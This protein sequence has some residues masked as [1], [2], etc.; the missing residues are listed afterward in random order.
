MKT[1]IGY[2]YLLDDLPS[3]YSGY[4]I[5]TNFTVG[6]KISN[7]FEDDNLDEYTQFELAIRLLFEEIPDDIKLAIDGVF[8]FMNGGRLV[9]TSNNEPDDYDDETDDNDVEYDDNDDEEVEEYDSDDDTK[10]SFDF[11]VDSKEIFTAFKRTFNIDLHHDYVHWFDFLAYL[12]D[13]DECNFTRIQ[14]IRTKSTKG[15]SKEE[16][17]KYA[18]LKSKYMLPPTAEEIK[19]A[20]DLD[21]RVING[22]PQWKNQWL[23]YWFYDQLK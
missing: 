23:G 22:I 6:I 14:E 17:S 20:K 12:S 11:T 8:W 15:M 1:N 2:N 4:R 18:S 10:R 3:E 13:L 9:N 7:I 5:R 16:K 21:G 19:L